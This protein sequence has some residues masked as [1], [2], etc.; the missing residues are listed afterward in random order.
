MVATEKHLILFLRGRIDVLESL[1]TILTPSL[2]SQICCLL[3][4]VSVSAV[5]LVLKILHNNVCN[6]SDNDTTLT[7][8]I[9]CKVL[10]YLDDKYS[11]PLCHRLISLACFWTP[12]LLLNTYVPEDVGMPAITNWIVEEGV[13]FVPSRPSEDN[14]VGCQNSQNTENSQGT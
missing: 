6:I 1:N 9:K 10:N 3:N 13:K 12:G 14:H 8:D 11:D 5:L 4:T 2:I 7:S